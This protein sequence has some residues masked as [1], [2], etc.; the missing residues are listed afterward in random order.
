M[1]VWSH[2]DLREI[3]VS[4]SIRQEAQTYTNDSSEATSAETPA[5]ITTARARLVP[6]P[7]DGGLAS[8]IIVDTARGARPRSMI[9]ATD[10]PF[11]GLGG[12]HN[13]RE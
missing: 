2:I 8:I 11:L 9:E 6:V 13:F 12:R 5:T 3:D 7:P 1:Y 4:S 10:R